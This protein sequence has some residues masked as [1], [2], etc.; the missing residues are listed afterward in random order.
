MT[1]ALGR[2]EWLAI[3]LLALA[4]I[5]ALGILYVLVDIYWLWL[6]T[7]LRAQSE[8]RN[9]QSI[10]DASTLITDLAE[11]LWNP[12][13]GI[14]LA[15]LATLQRLM[16]SG[17]EARALTNILTSFINARLSRREQFEEAGESLEDVS[18][19]LA[20]L[21]SPDVRTY[22][23]RRGGSISLTNLDFRGVP[24]RGADLC[25]LNLAGCNFAGC[26]LTRAKVRRADF[27]GAD[28]SH[29][30]AR[31]SNFAFACLTMATLAGA[32]FISSRL[33][34]ADF[35]GAD[36]SNTD[37]TK[38]QVDFA[39]FSDSDVSGALLAEAT[40]LTQM[41]LESA[42]GDS[43]TTVPERLRFTPSKAHRRKPPLEVVKSA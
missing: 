18:L 22:L 43:N 29:A 8:D 24:L 25:A 42:I 4:T 6:R 19:A 9:N 2:T 15:T 7:A 12:R 11:K 3:G 20:L 39:D 21:T 26:D 37:F 10:R 23:E 40:G 27:T 1:A 5:L 28:L 13:I 17:N 33:N 16:S 41:Q 38:A 30:V 32:D 14:R 34:H 36:L 35:T 31:D